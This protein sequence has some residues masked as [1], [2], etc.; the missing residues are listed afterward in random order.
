MADNSMDLMSFVIAD[1]DTGKDVDSNGKVLA[2]PI[3][4]A[5]TGILTIAVKA[6]SF[7]LSKADLERQIEQ[8]QR[9]DDFYKGASKLLLD[10]YSGY[11]EKSYEINQ[12]II[13]MKRYE[14]YEDLKKLGSFSVTSYSQ[15]HGGL[16]ND[17]FA[18]FRY[19]LGNG[20]SSIID[21]LTNDVNGETD[22][23]VVN[24]K[25]SNGRVRALNYG[26][27]LECMRRTWD[28]SNPNSY[29]IF[30]RPIDPP[31]VVL[32]STLK[33]KDGNYYADLADDKFGMMISLLTDMG[34]PSWM[35]RQIFNPINYANPYNLTNM[36]NIEKWSYDGGKWFTNLGDNG[37]FYYLIGQRHHDFGVNV[38]KVQAEN[39]FMA[40]LKIV[41][42]YNQNT[43]EQE[44]AE[45]EARKQAAIAAKAAQDAAN[46][47][48]ITTDTSSST[49]TKTAAQ[50]NI[51]K[52]QDAAR[53]RAAAA[54]ATAAAAAAKKAADAAAA[55]KAAD[56][57][58]VASS[59]VFTSDQAKKFIA[60]KTH[61]VIAKPE[62]FF[63]KLTMAQKIGVAA[64]AGIG[65]YMVTK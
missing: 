30:L 23:N 6:T 2:G 24:Q 7:F 21:V 61:S 44:M 42:Q 15:I 35:W 11:N 34:C 22:I 48:N 64:A 36:A 12:T 27:W 41:N 4:A 5:I 60:S 8:Q 32:S 57:T 18:E 55:A 59:Q 20:F 33:G 46:A 62:N 52:M 9:I 50:I 19:N 49:V 54:A 45:I 13:D 26:L 3:S 43:F 39:D 28:K 16:V 38:G 51:E 1:L 53:K 65:A 63:D 14:E 58:K 40:V 29:F 17:G 31:E 10:L 56:Q 47:A 25:M 37:N